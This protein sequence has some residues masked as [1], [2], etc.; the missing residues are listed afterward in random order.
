MNTIKLICL[1]GLLSSTG[2]ANFFHLSE[3]NVVLGEKQMAVVYNLEKIK[4]FR[5]SSF[6]VKDGSCIIEMESPM[7]LKPPMLF[8]CGDEVYLNYQ[9]SGNKVTI[10]DVGKN[11][12]NLTSYLTKKMAESKSNRREKLKTPDKKQ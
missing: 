12:A 7:N 9:I 3:E 1:M 11:K 4:G 6:S 2:Y 10:F 8:R 5:V